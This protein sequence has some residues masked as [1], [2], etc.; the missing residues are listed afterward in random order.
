MKILKWIVIIGGL[1]VP[2]LIV[3]GDRDRAI[4]VESAGILHGLLPVSEVIMWWGSSFPLWA[5]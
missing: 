4:R 2:A 5:P 1:A 3:W